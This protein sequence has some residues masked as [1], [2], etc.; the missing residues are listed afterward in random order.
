MEER[1]I[2]DEQAR[3]VKMRKTENGF[4]DVTDAELDTDETPFA[5]LIICK[6]GRSVFA[7]EWQAPETK[8][9]TSPIFSIIAPKYVPSAKSFAA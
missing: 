3:G 8:P 1:I 4:V 9:S 7:V 6:P 2:D 5:V